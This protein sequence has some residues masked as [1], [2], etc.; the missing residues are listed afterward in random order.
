M[1]FHTA[2]FAHAEG[3]IDA[4]HVIAGFAQNHRNA[5]AR[6]G[7]TAHDL[8]DAFIGFHAAH[9]Q[10]VGIGVLLGVFDPGQGK[11]GQPGSG[12]FNALYLKAQICQGLYNLV[13]RGGGVEVAFQPGK[14]EF[15]GPATGCL[16]G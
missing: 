14:R 5:R 12:V 6:I 9:P 2:D 10:P 16:N 7:R 3:D 13:Q 4:R 15:H 11:A 1:A 8:L